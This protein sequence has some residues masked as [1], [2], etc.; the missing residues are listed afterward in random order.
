MEM[1][2]SLPKEMQS[3]PVSLFREYY[4]PW[5]H[6]KSDTAE[7]LTHKAIQPVESKAGI[8]IR[9]PNF[10]AQSLNHVTTAST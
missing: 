9:K 5:G 1:F 10:K 3:T 4:N 7:R 2:N 6:K 8:S